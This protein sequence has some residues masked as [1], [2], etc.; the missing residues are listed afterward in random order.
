M[1]DD[2]KIVPRPTYHGEQLNSAFLQG[3]NANLVQWILD[4]ADLIDSLKHKLRGETED[5]VKREWVMVKGAMMMNDLGVND[6]LF[7]LECNVFRGGWLTNLSAEE[8]GLTIIDLSKA[9]NATLELN[10]ERWDVNVNMVRSISTT[11]RNIIYQILK[12]AQ[13]GGFR[14]FL[15]RTTETKHTVVDTPEK[16]KGLMSL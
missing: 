4:N 13:G 2:Q 1:V 15:G 14:N 6:T 12:T 5:Y 11:V 16:K 10:I 9:Y 8:V 3:D 7:F